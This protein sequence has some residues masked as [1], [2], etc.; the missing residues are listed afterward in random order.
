MLQAEFVVAPVGDARGASRRVVDFGAFVRESDSVALKVQVKDISTSGC[1]LWT[2]AELTP[3]SD[4]WIKISGL[5]PVKAR[6]AWVG[7]GEAGCEFSNP[8]HESII[9]EL[10]APGRKIAK[11]T[12]GAIEQNGPAASR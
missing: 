10:L 7:P 12:F 3:Q 4:I 8:I 1:G 9:E 2:S 11:G 6:V 5:P